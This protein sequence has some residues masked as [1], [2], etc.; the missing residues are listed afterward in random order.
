[1]AL[2]VTSCRRYHTARKIQP[3]P[4]LKRDDLVSEGICSGEEQKKAA[5]WNRKRRKRRMNG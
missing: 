2:F 3:P 5:R 4:C 1:V